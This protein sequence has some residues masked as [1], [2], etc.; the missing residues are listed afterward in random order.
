MTAPL[1]W[2]YAVPIEHFVEPMAFLSDHRPE[3]FSPVQQT[4]PDPNSVY[5]GRL[6]PRIVAALNGDTAE[7]AKERVI[8]DLNIYMYM[9]AEQPRGGY[10]LRAVEPAFDEL[11]K[12]EV[13]RE[14]I[15]V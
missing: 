4:F 3:E 2:M 6:I 14:W 11:R 9:L 12:S 10:G 1:A 15:T 13:G 7:W 8:E 5:E